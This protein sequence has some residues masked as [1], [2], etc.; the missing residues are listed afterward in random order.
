M[1]QLP[2]TN[3]N[4]IDPEYLRS[5][6]VHYRDQ[7]RE[8]PTLDIAEAYNQLARAFDDEA[9]AIE[10]YTKALSDWHRAQ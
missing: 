1:S 5:R 8:A 7:A 4:M 9:T 2:T 3:N 10:Q 6:A